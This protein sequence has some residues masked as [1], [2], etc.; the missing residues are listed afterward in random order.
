MK[1]QIIREELKRR[2]LHQWELAK[3]LSVGESTLTRRLREELS[4]E[5][6]QHILCVIKKGG[7][8]D[9]E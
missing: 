6:T 9:N 7:K 1:N 3:L 4:E 5:E 2:G 8:T